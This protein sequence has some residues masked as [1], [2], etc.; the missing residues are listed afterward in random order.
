M[1]ILRSRRNCNANSVALIININKMY[2]HLSRKRNSAKNILYENVKIIGLFFFPSSKWWFVNDFTKKLFK[3]D[4][5]SGGGRAE[6]II[7][8]KKW[9]WRW[10]LAE[11]KVAFKTKIIWSE[12]FNYPYFSALWPL[13]ISTII[14]SATIETLNLNLFRW[15]PFFLKD[16][17]SCLFCPVHL[18]KR[19]HFQT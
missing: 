15:K 10:R 2:C 19:H 12:R 14:S 11:E 17:F 13:E 8:E 6:P 7:S 5:A 4:I 18:L 16:S 3:S 9:W 1:P